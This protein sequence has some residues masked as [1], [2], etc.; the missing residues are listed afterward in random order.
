MCFFAVVQISDRS[1]LGICWRKTSNVVAG[2]ISKTLRGIHKTQRRSQPKSRWDNQGKMFSYIF[3]CRF[4]INV[5]TK[6]FFGAE[7]I[8]EGSMACVVSF[9]GVAEREKSGI[10]R[11]VDENVLFE[12][13]CCDNAINL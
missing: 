9:G 11:D 13:I 7:G 4:H 12:D 5:H 1:V 8:Y 10:K 3:Y 2:N 6:A